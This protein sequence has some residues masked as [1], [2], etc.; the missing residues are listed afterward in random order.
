M[1]NDYIEKI[2][3]SINTVMQQISA[4]IEN[5]EFEFVDELLTTRLILLTDL[6]EA[7]PNAESEFVHQ[8]LKNLQMLD[9]LMMTQISIERE[10]IKNAILNVNKLTDYL[11]VSVNR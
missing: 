5:R 4:C 2:T 10:K 6:V 8:Y 9:S 3:I 11:Q 7:D 1:K